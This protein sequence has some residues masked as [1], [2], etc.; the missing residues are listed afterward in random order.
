[1]NSFSL[2]RIKNRH[3]LTSFASVN[4]YWCKEADFVLH[5]GEATPGLTVS[6]ITGCESWGE[7]LHAASG[8]C[9]GLV[10]LAVGCEATTSAAAAAGFGCVCGL[11]FLCLCLEMKNCVCSFAPPLPVP[12][13]IRSMS[14]TLNTAGVYFRLIRG[15][16]IGLALDPSI[17]AF[18]ACTWVDLKH[19]GCFYKEK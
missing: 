8:R 17:P 15:W 3:S 14:R 13:L 6:V 10:L 9:A 18:P 19:P 4:V 5:F 2:C 16:V 1:M 12:C 11:S 7:A